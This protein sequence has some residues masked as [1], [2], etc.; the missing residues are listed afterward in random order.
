M[1]S[2]FLRD[3]GKLILKKRR[4]KLD[5][6]TKTSHRR[7]PFWIWASVL[8]SSVLLPVSS[9]Q[10]QTTHDMHET[11]NQRDKTTEDENSVSGCQNKVQQTYFSAS[12]DLH[13]DAWKTLSFWSVGNINHRFQPIEDLS[14]QNTGSGIFVLLRGFQQIELKNRRSLLASPAENSES[15][16]WRF[17]ARKIQNFSE[18]SE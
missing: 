6:E 12:F 8:W 13:Y 4:G 7:N 17:L 14:S 5:N 11:S 9:P 10:S 1:C 16:F 15:D 3:W 2:H 18:K